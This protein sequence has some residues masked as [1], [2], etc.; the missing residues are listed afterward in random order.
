MLSG[1]LLI[2]VRN[3]NGPRTVPWGTPD[4]TW[5]GLEDN[6]LIPF[7]EKVL[8]SR[9]Q[10]ALY[11]KV[12]EAMEEPLVRYN[13]EPFRKVQHNSINLHRF[14]ELNMMDRSYQLG[15]AWPS[16]SAW[17]HIG[18]GWGYCYP[19]DGPWCDERWCVP[20][21][22]NKLMWGIQAYNWRGQ[23]IHT[24]PCMAMHGQP[25]FLLPGSSIRS[26]LFYLPRYPA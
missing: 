14:L 7:C 20:S 23:I 15:L 21:L 1:R 17:I 24:S 13:I 2:Y 18:Y 9:K 26:T 3:S 22:C 8:Y 19:L 11:A 12:L 10:W 4:E 5:T 25:L 6:G 16:G